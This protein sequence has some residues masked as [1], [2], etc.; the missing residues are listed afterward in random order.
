MEHRI[1]GSRILNRDPAVAITRSPYGYVNDNPLNGADPTGLGSF[2]F[3]DAGDL[4]SPTI[5]DYLGDPSLLQGMNPQQLLDSLGGR[6]GRVDDLARKIVERRQGFR[7]EDLLRG[8]RR[9]PDPL[10]SGE[11]SCRSS[12]RSL[13]GCLGRQ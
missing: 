10:E 9:L 4:S 8:G 13:L 2:T 11:R 7:L 1:R 12:G 5:W 3:P 6:A